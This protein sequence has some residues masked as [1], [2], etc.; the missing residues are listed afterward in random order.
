[1]KPKKLWMTFLII[2]VLLGPISALADVAPIN[3]G[4]MFW[5]G[6]WG[7]NLL[8]G[9]PG[10]ENLDGLYLNVD[11]APP[12]TTTY[13]I[14]IDTTINFTD[15]CDPPDYQN[16]TVQ[17]DCN[18]KDLPEDPDDLGIQVT[19]VG[20][21]FE[22]A[23]FMNGIGSEFGTAYAEIVDVGVDG[24][25]DGIEIEATQLSGEPDFTGCMAAPLGIYAFGQPSTPQTWSFSTGG[26]ETS[27]PT[28]TK[29]VVYAPLVLK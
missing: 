1:M 17:F 14:G 25:Y 24:S 21:E 22:E 20:C 16:F 27:S 5:D 29:Y 19:F 23:V 3:V 7:T 18:Q 12:G 4:D 11:A 9:L 2:A 10:S 28:G 15:Y 8:T 13:W 6:N 26:F